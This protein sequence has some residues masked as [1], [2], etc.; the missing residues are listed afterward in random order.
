VTFQRRRPRRRRDRRAPAFAGDFTDDGRDITEIL[1]RV[2][3]ADYDGTTVSLSDL[4]GQPRYTPP[5]PAPVVGLPRTHSAAGRGWAMI[6]DTAAPAIPMDTRLRRA[7]QYLELEVADLEAQGMG[8]RIDDA[9]QVRQ[10][11]EDLDERSVIAAAVTKA[12]RHLM[13]PREPWDPR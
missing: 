8:Y 11:G 1:E 2:R 10:R 3:P 4:R 13:G 12:A 5:R 7:R 9:V 6:V